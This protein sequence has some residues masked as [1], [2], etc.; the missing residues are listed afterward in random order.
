MVVARD[1]P[2]SS[3]YSSSKKAVVASDSGEQRLRNICGPRGATN[4]ATPALHVIS[5]QPIALTGQDRVPVGSEGSLGR[6]RGSLGAREW[7]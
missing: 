1:L 7:L 2:F 4:V 5:L 3:A 6:T